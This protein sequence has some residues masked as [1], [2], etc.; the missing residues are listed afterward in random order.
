MIVSD[1][2]EGKPRKEQKKSVKIAEESF[3]ETA[4]S[5][6]DKDEQT[7]MENLKKLSKKKK[8]AKSVDQQFCPKCTLVNINQAER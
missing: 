1:E 3:Q 6:K 5:V 4:Q 2:N 8:S 7:R